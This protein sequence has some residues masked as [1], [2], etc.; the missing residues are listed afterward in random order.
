VT[1]DH[2]AAVAAMNDEFIANVGAMGYLWKLELQTVQKHMLPFFE[3]FFAALERQEIGFKDAVR[4]YCA[5]T[6]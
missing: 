4:Q 6:E 3:I 2:Q 1:Y 5:L